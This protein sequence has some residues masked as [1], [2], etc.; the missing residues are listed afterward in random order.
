MVYSVCS[1]QPEEGENQISSLLA[2]R[3]DAELVPVTPDILGG[4]SECITARGEVRTLPIHLSE[5]D[6]MD[7]FYAA[8]LMRK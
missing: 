4:M 5:L 7:G 2:E 1:M 8:V 3:K 6:G